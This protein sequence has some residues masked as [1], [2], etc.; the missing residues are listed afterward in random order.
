MTTDPYS[1]K[2][3]GWTIHEV[4]ASEHSANLI[5]QSCLDEGVMQNQLILHSDN[6][7]PMKGVTM[8][9][10]LERLGVTPSFSRPSVSDDNPYSESLFK[11]FK[12]HPDFPMTEK[13]ENIQGA[14]A[15]TEKFVSWYNTRHLHSA[16]KFV[17]PLQRHTGKDFAILDKRHEVYEKA[18]ARHPERWAGKTRNWAPDLI[19]T[20]NPDKKRKNFDDNHQEACEAA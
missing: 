15:W 8:L 7:S 11:T 13:F 4:E 12:Y 18:K 1:R 10:M 3:V 17:T 6:G 20:L 16:L 19:V 2:V 14:R 5:K 9:A